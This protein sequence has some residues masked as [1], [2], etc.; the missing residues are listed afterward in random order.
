MNKHHIEILIEAIKKSI[1]SILEGFILPPFPCPIS[2]HS[3]SRRL[4]QHPWQPDKLSESEYLLESFRQFLHRFPSHP[5]ALCSLRKHRSCPRIFSTSLTSN[6][7]SSVL[8]FQSRRVV[9]FKLRIRDLKRGRKKK[10]KKN[11]NRSANGRCFVEGFGLEKGERG[12]RIQSNQRKVN[13][14]SNKGFVLRSRVF[15]QHQID[16][17]EISISKVIPF[18]FRESE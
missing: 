12:E 1:P 13:T 9:G 11:R 2:T 3:P 5:P 6:Y 16:F 18:R 7:T 15:C 8:T 17:F 10:K 14:A 4:W